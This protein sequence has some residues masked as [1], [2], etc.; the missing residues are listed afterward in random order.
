MV[1]HTEAQEAET[2]AGS[3]Y[4]VELL[5][6]ELDYWVVVTDAEAQEAEATASSE[7]NYWHW[8]WI[9]DKITGEV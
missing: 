8:S 7:Y 1:I 9:T 6:L 3:E 4:T 2:T 5:A